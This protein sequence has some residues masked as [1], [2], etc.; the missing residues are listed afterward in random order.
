MFTFT[1]FYELL[2]NANLTARSFDNALKPMMQM[3]LD[4]LYDSIQSSLTLAFVV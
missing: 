1:S 4:Q 3:Q 2:S